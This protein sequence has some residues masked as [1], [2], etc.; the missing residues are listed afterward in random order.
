M[1]SLLILLL[2]YLAATLIILPIWTIMKIRGHDAEVDSLQQRLAYLDAELKELRSKPRTP[3]PEPAKATEAA[4]VASQPAAAAPPPVIAISR[5]P[6]P[7]E[8]APIAP[9]PV[10]VP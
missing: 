6:A 9:P 4:S 8:I 5:P 2:L 7:V 1:E 3:A 10:A